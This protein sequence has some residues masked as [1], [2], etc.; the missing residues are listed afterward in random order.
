M[1]LSDKEGLLGTRCAGSTAGSTVSRT[2]SEMGA[3]EPGESG[4][5]GGSLDA[6]AA[7]HTGRYPSGGL[8]V[9]VLPPVEESVAE[10]QRPPRP[11]SAP[12]PV[13]AAVLAAAAGEGVG[14]YPNPAGAE[15][16]PTSPRMPPAAARPGSPGAAFGGAGAPIQAPRSGSPVLPPT[17]APTPA[18]LAEA[19]SRAAAE[20]PLPEGA[21][22]GLGSG[23]GEAGMRGVSPLSERNAGHEEGGESAETA[24]ESLAGASGAESYGTAG[25][26]R[27]PGGAGPGS[28]GHQRDSSD[29][30]SSCA[31]EEPVLT[32]AYAFLHMH[33]TCQNGSS[34]HL[35]QTWFSLLHLLMGSV[36]MC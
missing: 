32:G 28:G 34:E 6:A 24:L 27:L 23:S 16:R 7:W 26:A 8:A 17:P 21:G 2:S 36:C 22:V 25:E 10:A 9:G 4:H 18:K 14:A 15:L 29:G 33:F 19:A 5:P 12:G 1:R 20:E 13:A 3:L 31:V 30:G 11:A 35:W